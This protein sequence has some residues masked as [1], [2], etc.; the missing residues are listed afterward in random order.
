MHLRYGVLVAA[1]VVAMSS[2]VAAQTFNADTQGRIDF[3]TA[4]YESWPDVFNGKSKPQT[5]RAILRLPNGALQPVPLVVIMHTIGGYYDENEGWF[6]RELNKKGYATAEVDSFTPRDARNM[7]KTG[8]QWISPTMISDA[9]HVL[10]SLTA[11][12]R[13][14]TNHAA[15]VGFSQGGEAAHLA[16]FKRLADRML[17]DGPRF[18]AHVPFYPPCGVTANPTSNGYSGAPVLMLLAEKDD[19][20][21]PGKC[22]EIVDL[23][24]R[25]GLPA[26]VDIVVY[27]GA[28]HGWTHPGNKTPHFESSAVSVG[29]CAPLLFAP[30][31]EVRNGIVEPVDNVLRAACT[32][33]TGYSMGYDAKVRDKSLSDL[34]DFL[35]K[36]LRG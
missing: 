14:D 23:Y 29:K 19:A 28:Y 15:I 7:V 6:A 22:R 34:I 13:V 10:A 18:A 33:K 12:P 27:P 1:A 30:G 2:G 8:G 24:K 16:A 11:H 4:Y 31:G 17:P 25:R 36:T 26:P 32:A 35:N 21:P 9:H 20:G 3:P 5:G